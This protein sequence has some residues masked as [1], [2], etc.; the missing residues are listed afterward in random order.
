MISLIIT[1]PKGRKYWRVSNES[2]Q[3]VSAH[4]CSVV[5]HLWQ[6]CGMNNEV[7][8]V[9]CI[10]HSFSAAYFD[11]VANVFGSGSVAS[12][13][14]GPRNTTRNRV[15]LLWASWQADH[16]ERRQRTHLPRMI[17]GNCTRLVGLPSN[18]RAQVNTAYKR[19]VLVFSQGWDK[20]NPKPKHL[21][22]S[23]LL[24]LIICESFISS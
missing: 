3:W 17:Q 4:D 14:S 23:H 18:V 5:L 24:R 12:Y 6:S 16:E 22:R 7:F 20:I 9:T 2:C 8:L 13:S 21:K 15:H 10:I 11:V 19:P 1:D